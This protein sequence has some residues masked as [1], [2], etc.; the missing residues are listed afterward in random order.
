[1]WCSVSCSPRHLPPHYTHQT[2]RA[3]TVITRPGVPLAEYPGY[4]CSRPLVV[5]SSL[6]LWRSSPLSGTKRT[7][8]IWGGGR[9]LPDS[10]F[11]LLPVVED[12]YPGLFMFLLGLYQEVFSNTFF[13]ILL[14]R[15]VSALL[16]SF[17]FRYLSFSY[18]FLISSDSRCQNFPPSP[19]FSLYKAI[20]HIHHHKYNRCSV[21][22]QQ[23]TLGNSTVYRKFNI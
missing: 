8:L 21:G 4:L 11:F 20:F 12:L 2:V 19:L 3:T 17:S 7:L 1:M 13:F 18:F 6:S 22:D 9:V 16:Y 23:L 15:E 10:L 14:A 5:S